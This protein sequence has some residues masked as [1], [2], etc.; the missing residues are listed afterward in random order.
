MR[1]LTSGRPTAVPRHRTLSATLDWSSG[2]FSK[3]EQM[4]LRRLSIFA[5]GFTLQAAGAVAVDATHPQSAM[6]D[7]VAELIAKSLVAADVGD[8][9]PR[10]RLLDPTRVYALDKLAESGPGAPG[11]ACWE[12]R[13]PAATSARTPLPAISISTVNVVIAPMVHATASPN[14]V[15]STEAMVASRKA[16]TKSGKTE[17]H[18]PAPPMAPR[19]TAASSAM[20]FRRR[21]DSCSGQHR[22]IP[23]R[24]RPLYRFRDLINPVSRTREAG[25]RHVE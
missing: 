7:Q 23:Y 13:R 5:G 1:L 21:C 22:D 2:L 16:R 24:I 17:A 15:N 10:F 6:I 3:V 19:T 12:E 11:Q 20:D 25:R 8:A 4:I 14:V 9:E 18:V